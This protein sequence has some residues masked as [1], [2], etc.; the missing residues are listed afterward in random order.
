MAISCTSSSC[1]GSNELFAAS[2]RLQ[3]EQNR[4]RSLDRPDAS[5]ATSAR[6]DN[7]NANA[8]SAPT[9]SVNTSGQVVG[10]LLNVLA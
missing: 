2:S 1:S 4:I 6:I 7:A 8:T 3:S 9:P 10:Q 5:G